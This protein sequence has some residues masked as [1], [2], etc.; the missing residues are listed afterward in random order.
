MNATTMLDSA[1][2]EDPLEKDEDRSSDEHVTKPWDPKDIRI[3]T[4]T[5]TI[6]EI[7]TQVQEGELDLAPDF[8]RD[9]VWKVAQ[10]VR[11]IESVLLGIPLPAFYFN[12]DK[13]GAIQVVDGVQRLT[14]IRHFMRNELTLDR[15]LLEYLGHLQGKTYDTLEPAIKRRFAS[16]Q[17]VAH[18]I[19]PQTP[20]EVKYDIF[21]RVNTGGTP[22][23]AQEIRHCMSKVQSRALLTKLALSESFDLATEKA[24]WRRVDGEYVREN[25]RMAD[26]EL[27]LRFCAFYVT[28][29]GEYAKS[30]SLDAFLM[31]FTKRLDQN[32]G[33]ERLSPEHLEFVFNRAMI[34]CH[35]ILGKAAFRRWQIGAERRGPLN[36]A[37]FE[38]QAIAL[39]DY[40][41]SD[42]MPH[43]NR[44][45]QA[46][47]ELFNEEAYDSAVRFGTGSASRVELRLA[48]TKQVIAEILSE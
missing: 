20:D 48:R 17:L 3:T 7:F 4:K 6:R 33:D 44:I 31:E 8:Q 16:T 24:F 27:V 23:T 2:D 11:L 12:Q 28:S 5:F 22:L 37:V 36:R 25:R 14:T 13:T 29:I 39:A 9:F 35:T 18:L 41:L 45:A 32:D 38:S 43:C 42:L 19:E 21:S 10:Q 47:R 34:N 46:F 30:S 15:R 1:I 40:E 26:R